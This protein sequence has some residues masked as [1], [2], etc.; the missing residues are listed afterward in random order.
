MLFTLENAFIFYFF[1]AAQQ[2]FGNNEIVQKYHR[3][4]FFII[5]VK[6]IL[7]FYIT[8][9]TPLLLFNNVE[10]SQHQKQIF[11]LR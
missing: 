1:W 8:I 6:T 10:T 9:R 4:L 2:T 5:N 11:H 7:R 3:N